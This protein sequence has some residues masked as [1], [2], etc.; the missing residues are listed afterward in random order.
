MNERLIIRLM[1]GDRRLPINSL[2]SDGVMLRNE[3][4]A[5]PRGLLFEFD[6][7]SPVTK[8]RMDR[9]RTL[10]DWGPREFKL[11]VHL[12]D[13]NLVVTGVDPRAFPAGRYWFRLKVADLN[14]PKEKVQVEI[15]EDGE[16]VRDIPVKKDKRDIRLTGNINSFDGEIRRILQATASRVDGGAASDWLTSHEP[17]PRRKACLLNLLAKLRT[18]PTPASPLIGNVQH[19]FFADVDRAYAR[20]DREF[21]TRIDALARDPKKP[22]FAEGSPKSAVHR[23]LLDRIAR[24]EGDVDKYRLESFRQEGKN[25]MQAVVAILPDPS[26]N[27]Y[28]DLDIDLGNPLQDVV[29]LFIHL[30]ELIDPGK[31][32]HLALRAKLAKNKTIAPFLFY[33]VVNN[34]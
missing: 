16:L 32:D 29:G 6:G 12:S 26:R 8:F 30:G 22:F 23:Q 31:T 10:R 14:L 5:T 7:D 28:A 27:F 13:G 20:V 18:S 2:S 34:S 4:D 33:E 15:P 19:V 1:E 24:F 17:R 21:F 11:D 3:T 25:S 9:V